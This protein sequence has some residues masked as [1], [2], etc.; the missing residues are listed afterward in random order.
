MQ[1]LNLIRPENSDIKYDI[2]Q[3]PDGEPHI[4]LKDWDNEVLPNN[5]EVIKVV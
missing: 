1:V 4:V 5:V 3:F 2:I